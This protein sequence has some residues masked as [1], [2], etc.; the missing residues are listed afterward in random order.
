MEAVAGSLALR[1]VTGNSEAPVRW[2]AS[3][4]I[5]SSVIRSVVALIRLFR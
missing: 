5:S 2:P 4:I 1:D 3:G